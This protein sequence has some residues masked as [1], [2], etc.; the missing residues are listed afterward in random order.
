MHYKFPPLA[1]TLGQWYEK[2][3]LSFEKKQ[4]QLYLF[5]LIYIKKQYPKCDKKWFEKSTTKNPTSESIQLHL[6]LGSFYF[7]LVPFLTSM[8]RASTTVA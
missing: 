1:S 2:K 4:K 7:V 5:T 8:L 3:H 6:L